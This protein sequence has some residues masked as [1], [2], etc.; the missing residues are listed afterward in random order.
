M[1][2]TDAPTVIDVH[3]DPDDHSLALKRLTDAL[4][5]RVRQQQA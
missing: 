5:K 2:R 4:G 3:L 1:E